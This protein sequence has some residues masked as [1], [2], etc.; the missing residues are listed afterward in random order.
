MLLMK[1]GLEYSQISLHSLAVMLTG[2][3]KATV[4]LQTAVLKPSAS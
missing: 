4:E 3:Y 2:L 1:V